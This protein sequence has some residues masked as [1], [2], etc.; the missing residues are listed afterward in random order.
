M[1]FD[2]AT[3]VNV[4]TIMLLAWIAVMIAPGL[5]WKAK[6]AMMGDVTGKD[7]L[8][9]DVINFYDPEILKI[10]SG[11]KIDVTPAGPCEICGGEIPKITGVDDPNRRANAL[12]MRSYLYVGP[13]GTGNYDEKPTQICKKCY[14]HEVG[15]YGKE[16]EY[17]PVIRLTKPDEFWAK[18][19]DARLKKTK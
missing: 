17:V 10:F 12:S 15:L 16:E 9:E 5:C 7:E 8:V 13:S 1:A 3:F 11:E 18:E 19:E 4:V 14:E 2:F 6:R